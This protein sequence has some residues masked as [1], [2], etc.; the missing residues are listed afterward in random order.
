MIFLRLSAVITVFILTAGCGGVLG[1]KKLEHE[2]QDFNIAL[3]QTNDEQMLLNLVR[4]KYP[5]RPKLDKVPSLP[6]GEKSKRVVVPVL[7]PP[8]IP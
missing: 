5:V 1:S 6:F 8:S 7:D 3:Q 4:M 2:R